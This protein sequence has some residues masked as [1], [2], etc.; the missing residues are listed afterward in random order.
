MPLER[1]TRESVLV[2]LGRYLLSAQQS[3]A[4][5]PKDHPRAV[6]AL[7]DL[8]LQTVELLAREG[9][10]RFALA[11]G[12]FIIDNEPLPIRNE[13]LE[14]LSDLFYRQGIGRMAVSRGV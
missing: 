11:D 12:E 14:G 5:D 9:D 8:Y 6:A 4:I 1:S 10:L 13:V 2:E 3:Q 7:R